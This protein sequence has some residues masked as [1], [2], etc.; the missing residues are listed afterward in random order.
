MNDKE[1]IEEIQSKLMDDDDLMS[2]AE[3]NNKVRERISK[4]A[5]ETMKDD[6]SFD[7]DITP[8]EF[9]DMQKE[10]EAVAAKVFENFI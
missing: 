8:D 7:I 4:H 3:K 6:G 9:L 5:D 10:N 2:L 1:L